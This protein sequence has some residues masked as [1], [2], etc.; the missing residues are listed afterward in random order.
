MQRYEAIE[1]GIERKD[2]KALRE[3]I[4]SIIYTS[5]NF[6]SGEFDE[7]IKYVESKGIKLKDDALI[8]EPTISSQK[9]TFTKEDFADAIFELK[10]NFCD[11]RKIG[12]ASCRERV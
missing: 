12:R 1:N 2:I 8:G 5:R 6:S 9:D 4:G 11:E 3:A 7:A 10:E